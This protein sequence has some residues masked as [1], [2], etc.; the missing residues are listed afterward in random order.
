[1]K[2][3]LNGISTPIAGI[4]WT[5]N[6]TSKD[7]FSHLFLYL[8]SKRILVN[9]IEMEKKEWCIESV[10]EI[11]NNLV[12]ATENVSLN[13]FDLQSIRNLIDGCNTYLD[14]VSPMNLPYIIFKDGEHWEDINFDKAMKMFRSTFKSE[15]NNIEQRYKLQF[16]KDIPD[17]F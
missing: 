6:R 3:E 2:Y 11:K 9:P 15:I 1:M 14:T 13:G 8:E 16:C 5:K 4:S 7:M 12:S 10:L 17:K